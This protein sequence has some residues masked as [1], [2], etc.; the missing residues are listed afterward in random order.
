LATPAVQA[1]VDF[2]GVIVSFPL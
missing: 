2:R 1:I